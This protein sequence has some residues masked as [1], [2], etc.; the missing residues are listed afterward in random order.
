MLVVEAAFTAAGY[1][2]YTIANQSQ[3][4]DNPFVEGGDAITGLFGA[5][6]LATGALVLVLIAGET[7]IFV[8]NR[9]RHHP[10]RSA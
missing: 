5:L 10:R 8:Y 2:L 3:P 7:A 6:L 9:F 4:E 1:V